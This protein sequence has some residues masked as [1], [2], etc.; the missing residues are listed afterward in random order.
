M[1]EVRAD[2]GHLQQQ[3]T[4]RVGVKKLH[5]E[6]KLPTYATVGSAG[7]DVYATEDALVPA[8]GYAHIGTG[9]AFE[10]PPGHVMLINGR[11]GHGFKHRVRLMNAQGIL[12][13]D[14][15]AELKVGLANDSDKDFEVKAGDRVA[16]IIVLPYPRIEFDEC[17]EL[18]DT[19]RGTGGFGSTGA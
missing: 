15:R 6:A 8:G 17:D 16:Q 1:S 5:P 4:L 19:E 2:Y 3:A 13:A 11:S 12:D 10:L 7:M 18:S 14:F 9:L